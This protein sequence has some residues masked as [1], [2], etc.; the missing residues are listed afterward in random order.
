MCP[1]LLAAFLGD[2]RMHGGVD[3]R[4]QS[5]APVIVAADAVF[6]VVDAHPVARLRIQSALL[7]AVGVTE[8]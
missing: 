5:I 3:F 7:A 4:L 8:H 1:S 2:G 6:D